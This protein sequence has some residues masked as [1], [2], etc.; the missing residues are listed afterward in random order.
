MNVFDTDTLTIWSYGRH[1]EL[2]RR[3]AASTPTTLAITVITRIEVLQGRFASVTKAANT[4]E[5]MSA[6]ERLSDTEE[7]L[8][9]FVVLPF[10]PRAFVLLDEYRVAKATKS[11]GLS[12]L[13]IA[14]IAK[15]HEATLISRNLNDFRLIPGLRVENWVDV[16]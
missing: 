8:K 11:I 15:A 6:L 2:K 7:K 13:M 1:E 5:L 12:D 3:V 4:R 9:Q 14:S 10:L 16:K